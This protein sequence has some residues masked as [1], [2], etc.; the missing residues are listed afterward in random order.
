M[1][2]H[3]AVAAAHR[4]RGIATALVTHVIARIGGGDT[5]FTSTN[6]SNRPAQHLFDKLG[7]VRS[8]TI[9]NIDPGDPE[10]VYVLPPENP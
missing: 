3:V 10:W 6:A 2:R 4:R 9:D 1:D 7:F 5:F 8:G